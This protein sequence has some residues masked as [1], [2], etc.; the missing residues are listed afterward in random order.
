MKATTFVTLFF[1][2]LSSV[3]ALPLQRRD[4]SELLAQLTQLS[5]V[6]NTFNEHVPAIGGILDLDILLV[7]NS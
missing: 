1:V 7:C 5:S 2:T 6:A 3:S 4:A